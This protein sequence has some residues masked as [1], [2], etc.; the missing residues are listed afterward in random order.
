MP[1]DLVAPPD[2]SDEVMLM[3]C[4]KCGNE[5]PDV[6]SQCQKC[7]YIFPRPPANVRKP[8]GRAGSIGSLPDGDTPSVLTLLGAV[9]AAAVLGLALWWLYSPEGL[10]LPDGAYVNDRQAFAISVPADWMVL[11]SDNY[12]E[13]FEK[14]GDRFPKT[15]QEGLSERKIEVGFMKLLENADFSP[16]V[17]IVIVQNEVPALNEEQK[18]EAAR[19]LS[20]E[21][22]RVLDKYKLERSELITVDD[23]TSLRFTSRGAM[24]FK[25]ADSEPVYRETMPGWRTATRHTPAEWKSFDLQFLQVLVPGKKR[26]YIITCTAM[27]SQ[28]KDFRR[29]FENA[30]ESFRVIERPPRF[31]PIITGGLQGGIIGALGYLLYYIVMALVGLVK[32]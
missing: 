4:P 14:L 16:S 7:R 3:T 26:A 21:F 30:I 8:I 28:Y 31:G 6:F 13:M 12:E 22:G 5:Q 11:T 18:E 2:T 19:A 20:A 15:L 24:K 9:A 32:R 23:L 25:V 1:T 10:P 29:S 27:V 17:N